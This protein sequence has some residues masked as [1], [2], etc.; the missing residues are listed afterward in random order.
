M[1]LQLPSEIRMQIWRYAFADHHVVPSQ[2]LLKRHKDGC[3]ACGHSDQNALP[4]W[5]DVFRPLL[6][7]KQ[8]FS[9]ARNILL[10]SFTLHLG[11]IIQST[12]CVKT[13]ARLGI[14][15]HVRR[16][17]Y[18]VHIDEDTRADWGASLSL[19]RHVFPNVKHLVIHA[20]VRPPDSYEKL[21]DGIYLALPI[22]RLKHA[23]GDLDL[24][25]N[26]DYI[27]HDVMFESPFLGEITTE[28]ALEEHELVVRDMIKDDEFIHEALYEREDGHALTLILVR[29]ARA[30]E[31]R[32]FQKLQRRRLD[33]LLQRERERNQSQQDGG[34]GSPGLPYQNWW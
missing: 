2:S 5:S 15:V 26:F 29:I 24:T 17:E 8:I 32:W 19:V 20:H 31:E 21:V 1:L 33:Q 23:H 34:G 7:C 22:I 4:I 13:S 25:M 27:Y 10:S 6:A 12:P 30:H 28:D 14:D 18:W 11:E 3:Q 16:L 9:E